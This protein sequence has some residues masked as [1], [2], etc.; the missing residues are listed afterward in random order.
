MGHARMSLD[1]QVLREHIES[2]PFQS[3]VDLG[4][5]QL[6]SISWPH[7]YINVTA[8]PHEG[9]PSFYC[10]QFECANY[11][12]AG[13]TARPWD[14]E[15]NKPLDTQK[16]PGGK[17]RIPKVFN[18]DWNN[19]QCLYLPCDKN[20]IKGHSDWSIKHPHLIW[21]NDSDITLYLEAVYELLNSSD[22]TGPRSA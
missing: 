17:A 14:V 4:K 5:W 22:Y 12:V 1:E 13:V 9:W 10:F 7:V 2:G 11:P 3:G 20:A 15:K 18:P 8:T 19:G 6:V 21:K 16:W